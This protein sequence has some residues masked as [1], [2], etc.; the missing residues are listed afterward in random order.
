MPTIIEIGMRKLCF[1]C[2]TCGS[3]EWDYWESIYWV[4]NFHHISLS[5]GKNTIVELPYLDKDQSSTS[6]SYDDILDLV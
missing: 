1:F 5:I 4:D 2:V 6:V 3:S